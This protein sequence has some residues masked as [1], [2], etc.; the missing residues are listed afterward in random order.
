MKY[1]W[2]GLSQKQL[3]DSFAT[4]L[5]SMIPGDEITGLL[6]N[7]SGMCNS[8]IIDMLYGPLEE[9]DYSSTFLWPNT[10]RFY[11]I[12]AVWVCMVKDILSGEKNFGLCEWCKEFL[13]MSRSD[14]RYCNENSSC[15]V[16][17]HRFRK[18]Y[19]GHQ[20]IS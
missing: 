1:E 12:K 18:K 20:R 19:Y 16:K 9:I 4:S 13:P 10:I 2:N 15:K 3:E 7:R 14:Q 17:A 6:K 8:E 5:Q 11:D